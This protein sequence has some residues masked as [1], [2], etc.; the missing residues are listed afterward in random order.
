MLN[1]VNEL[2]HVLECAQYIYILNHKLP[3][4]D[5]HQAGSQ[6]DKT[7]ALTEQT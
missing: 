1:M 5:F 2:I 4:W 6:Q 7:I 3:K